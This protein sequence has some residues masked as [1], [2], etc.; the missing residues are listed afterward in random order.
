MWRFQ[1]DMC[2]PRIGLSRIELDSDYGLA[3][4]ILFNTQQ[5]QWQLAVR[6]PL[7]NKQTH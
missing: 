1:V 2:E 7:A 3:Q 6:V 4:R 5:Q